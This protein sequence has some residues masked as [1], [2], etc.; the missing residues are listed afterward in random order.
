[1]KEINQLDAAAVI[2]GTQSCYNTFKPVTVANVTTCY[3]V[4]SC[5]DKYGT[6]TNTYKGPAPSDDY[7]GM[8][9]PG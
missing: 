1:M 5:T 9:N 3:A 4:Q 7:C 6:V 8:R 2:G